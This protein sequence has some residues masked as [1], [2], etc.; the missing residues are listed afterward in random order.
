MEDWLAGA[1]L[2]EYSSPGSGSKVYCV[3]IS[4]MPQQRAKALEGDALLTLQGSKLAS[5]IIVLVR[6][7]CTSTVLYPKQWLKTLMFI[8]LFVFQFRPYVRL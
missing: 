2:K 8:F 1:D 7:A 3:S 4:S 5:P 6:L